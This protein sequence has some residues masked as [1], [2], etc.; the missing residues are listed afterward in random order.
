MRLTWLT[1]AL[2]AGACTGHAMAAVRDLPVPTVT[3]LP[4]QLIVPDQLTAR[5]FQTS[6]R[7]L[8]GIAT[9]AEQIVGREAR[10]RLTAGRPVPLGSLGTPLAIRRGAPATAVYQ[11]D[12]FSISTAAI[13][14]EDGAVG[15]VID[16]RATETGT[17]IKVEVQADGQL[18]VIG[19]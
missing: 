7:S 16:A 17:V 11:E 3:I 4:G 12:G 13:A 15:D 19:E 10:R 1:L 6:P 18:A 2:L 14:L 9:E 8:A 5:A